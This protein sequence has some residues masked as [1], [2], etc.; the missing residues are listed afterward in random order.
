MTTPTIKAKGETKLKQFL[1]LLDRHV[2]VKSTN[3]V[4]GKEEELN[5]VIE[6]QEAVIVINGEWDREDLIKI[7]NSLQ[8][9]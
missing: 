3:S 7:L 8:S 1:F 4:T 5:P 9:L 2:F 6:D